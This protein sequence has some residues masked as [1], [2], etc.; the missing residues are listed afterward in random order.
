MALAL[1]LGV[2]LGIR[3]TLWMMLGE[4]AGVATV[5][6]ATA[7][8]VASLMLLYPLAFQLLK[9]AGGAYLLYLGIQLW[10][11]KGKMSISIDPSTNNAISNKNLITQGYITAIANPKGW[12]FL[13]A[14]LPPFINQEYALIP[15]LSILIAIM[16]ALEFICMLAYALGGKALRSLLLHN[17]NILW[18]NR[19]AGILIIVISLWLISA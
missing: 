14:L 9:L 3:R 7:T 6:I 8:G 13:I 16:L 17:N 12:A 5:A 15:Q 1:T 4:L 11:S 2:T 19:I 18:L 10:F